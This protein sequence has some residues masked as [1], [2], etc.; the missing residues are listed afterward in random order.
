MEI[1]EIGR[2]F[3]LYSRINS[4][5]LVVIWGFLAWVCATAG[6]KTDDTEAAIIAYLFFL[7]FV[8]LALYF[9]LSLIETV[10]SPKNFLL[11]GPA[12]RVEHFFKGDK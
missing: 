10:V 1:S 2:E 7:A 11:N 6:M 5:I 12:S 8:G 3:L 4:A 9:S